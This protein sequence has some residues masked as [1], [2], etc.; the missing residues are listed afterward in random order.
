M[1]NMFEYL[2]D[3]KKNW[4]FYFAFCLLPIYFIVYGLIFILKLSTAHNYK[5]YHSL[6]KIKA[7]L[8]I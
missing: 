4:Y 5:L 2:K 6:R 7:R 1:S 3:Y 8:G